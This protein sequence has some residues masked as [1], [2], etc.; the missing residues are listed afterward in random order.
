MVRAVSKDEFQQWLEQ[1]R[2]EY[3]KAGTVDVA[4]R[5]TAE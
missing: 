1:A 5:A 2:Q 3:A 4:S